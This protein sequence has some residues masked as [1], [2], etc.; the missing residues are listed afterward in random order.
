MATQ[1][2]KPVDG[3]IPWDLLIDFAK[4]KKAEEER[5]GRPVLLD[6]QQITAIS[7]L[8]PLVSEP[9]VDENWTGKLNEYCQ[10]NGFGAIQW[11]PT[12]HVTLNVCGTTQSRSRVKCILPWR[13]EKFPQ[14]GYGCEAGQQ[15]PVFKKA[16]KAKHFAAMQAYRFLRGEPPQQRGDRQRPMSTAQEGSPPRTGVKAED[17]N[18]DGGVSTA[19]IPS[20]QADGGGTSGLGPTIRE[21]VA[22]LAGSQGFGIPHYEVERDGHPDDDTWQGRAYFQNDGRAPEDVGLVRGVVGREQAEDSVAQTL[23]DW[24]EKED[25]KRQEIARDLDH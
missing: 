17:D 5:T 6:H 20:R 1:S 13:N 24:L 10:R 16:Q 15:A 21:R 4:N 3:G 9:D 14:E 2:G 22:V 7:Q 12:E 11:L 23:L 25:Q 19:G 8:I 18:E